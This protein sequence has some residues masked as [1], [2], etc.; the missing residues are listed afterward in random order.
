MNINTKFDIG[1]Q[2]YIIKKG[3]IVNKNCPICKGTG[4]VKAKL[5]DSEEIIEC[6]CL[7]CNGTGNVHSK[8]DFRWSSKEYYDVEETMYVGKTIIKQE[9]DFVNAKYYITEIEIGK[10][11]NIRYKLKGI[12]LDGKK[13]K[14]YYMS[15]KED[16]IFATK[17][18][19]VQYCKEFNDIQEFD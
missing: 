6:K 3:V 12:S 2:V 19:A 18:E 14:E 16:E 8:K 15:L 5:L 7:K 11:K 10:D 1:Q 4:T 9:G 17:E 13:E